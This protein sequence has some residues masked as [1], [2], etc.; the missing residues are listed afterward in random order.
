[1]EKEAS[2]KRTPRR[3]TAALCIILAVALLSVITAYGLSE[4]VRGSINTFLGMGADK[5]PEAPP[6]NGDGEPGAGDKLRIIGFETVNKSIELCR[7]DVTRAGSVY[8]G[9]VF[10]PE[11]EKFYAIGA[12]TLVE[13][14]TFAVSIELDCGEELYPL[15]FHYCLHEDRVVLHCSAKEDIGN[16]DAY[17][18]AIPGRT[19]VVLIN[20]IFG[21]QSSATDYK[22]L[23]TLET[24]GLTDI[25]AVFDLEPLGPVH[26]IDIAGDLSGALFRTVDERFF[27]GNFSDKTIVP[28]EVITGKKVGH[29]SFVDSDTLLIFEYEEPDTENATFNCWSYGLNERQETAIFSGQYFYGDGEETGAVF[30][31]G[32][33][34]LEVDGDGVASI[35]D[36]K[37]GDKEPIGGYRYGEHSSVQFSPDGNRIALYEYLPEATEQ[38]IGIYDLKTKKM[39]AFTAIGGEPHWFDQDRLGIT[40]TGGGHKVLYLYRLK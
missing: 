38:S 19:D 12:D 15:N 14:E 16:V 29:C 22:V 3:V 26:E 9:V 33:Y 27:Y 23:L 17:P 20:Q 6:A 13:K 39:I 34:A 8:S 1:M 18:V 32:K 30:H 28:V 4:P 2:G 10:S 24:L 11:D 5:K 37:T 25:L 40:Q 21:R 31:G 35:V 36:L 7:V